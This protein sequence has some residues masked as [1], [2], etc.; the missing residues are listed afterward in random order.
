MDPQTTSSPEKKS[1]LSLPV[2]IIVAGLLVAG[3]IYLSRGESINVAQKTTG[4]DTLSAIEV[5][6]ITE[7]DH[8][9]GN[10]D[11]PVTLIE[12]SDL[13][14]PYCKSF[15]Q[16]MRA[17]MNE[18]GTDGRLA[19]VYRHFPL[20]QLHPKA[21]REAE[22]VEC[23]NELSNKTAT[24]NFINRIFEVTPANNGLEESRLLSLGE[25]LGVDQEDLL[26]CM[27]SGRHSVTV[28]TH[29]E[30]AVTSGGRGTPHSVLLLKDP[31]SDS[32]TEKIRAE[33]ALL[34]APDIV[35]FDPSG[36]VLAISGALPLDFMKKVIDTIISQ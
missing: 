27:N 13:E 29:L 30:D 14:C 5:N 2:A 34:G 20:V 12:F 23:V 16:T 4:E 28:A 33:A 6:P 9:I 18:Y 32:A 10:P 24:W 35:Q 36:K 22:A 17:L 11:A 15:H 1:T 7:D 25:E 19:W 26:S 31:I 21:P 8:F 3:A